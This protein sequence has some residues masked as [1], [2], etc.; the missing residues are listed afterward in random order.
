MT[1]IAKALQ[2][3]SILTVFNIISNNSV[4]NNEADDIATALS[5]VQY[6]QFYHI[7]PNYKSYILV[8]TVLR[9]WA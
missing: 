3:V 6:L 7:T 2:N 4:G 1:I 9:Q 5:H 8:V